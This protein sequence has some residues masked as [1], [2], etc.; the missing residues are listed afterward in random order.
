MR[1]PYSDAAIA[2]SSSHA[3]PIGTERDV[4]Y[5]RVVRIPSCQMVQIYD[6][7]TAISTPDHDMEVVSGSCN[8]S[9]VGAECDTGDS[10]FVLLER[11]QS[12]PGL[13]LKNA[14]LVSPVPGLCDDDSLGG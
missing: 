2:G 4:E 9:A 7:F 1:V 5:R 8:P 11:A 13:H 10:V 12:F 14:G 3:L 6:T